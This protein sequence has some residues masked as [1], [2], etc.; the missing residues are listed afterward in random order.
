MELVSKQRYDEY[1]DTKP[2][3]PKNARA[4]SVRRDIL[5]SIRSGSNVSLCGFSSKQL[6]RILSLR[7]HNET[8]Q[9]MFDV[10]SFIKDEIGFRFDMKRRNKDGRKRRKQ[11]LTIADLPSV[12]VGE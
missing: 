6:L 4:G 8:D 9:E 12:Q 3:S 2:A 11:P 5:R 1:R 7:L 10:D